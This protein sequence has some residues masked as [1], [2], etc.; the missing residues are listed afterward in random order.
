MAIASPTH[1][2][3]HE[4]YAPATGQGEQAG[5][6]ACEP[7]PFTVQYM[8]SYPTLQPTR[9]SG[10]QPATRRG[11]MFYQEGLPSD[12]L[13]KSEVPG[14]DL[15]AASSGLAGAQSDAGM[16][17]RVAYPGDLVPVADPGSLARQ[18]SMSVAPPRYNVLHGYGEPGGLIRDDGAGGLDVV[19]PNQRAP[20]AKRGP[21][22]DHVER[23]KTALTRKIGSCIRCRMQRIRVSGAAIHGPA[24]AACILMPRPQCNADPD[25]ERGICM[26]CKKI[27][28]KTWRLPCLRLKLSDVVLSKPGQVEGYEW[29]LRW[30][31]DTVL[32]DIG[33]WA[34]SEVKT[35][36][37]TEGYTGHHVQLQVRKFIPQEGDRLERSWVADDG[38][39]KSVK[40]PP[41][42]LVNQ[43]AAKVAYE[44]YIKKGLVECFKRLLGPGEEL[45]WQTYDRAV[46][47]QNDPS[48]PLRERE[49]LTSTMHLWMSIRLTTKS[50]EIVGNETL[51]MQRDITGE[52]SPLRG[53]IPLPPVMGAQIDSI[54]IHQIQSQLRH[55]TLD[56]LQKLTAD[57][58]HKTWLATYLVTFILLHNTALLMKHDAGYA[59]KHGM[60]VCRT[61]SPSPPSLPFSRA[62]VRW[63]LPPTAAGDNKRLTGM[64]P[65]ETICKGRQG[66]T[67]PS[68]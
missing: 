44:S 13:F 19:F 48:L 53:K 38:Q 23:Q 37:V 62:H 68:G 1:D 9:A 11:G 61:H 18:A 3:D 55:E 63:A 39:I 45:L 42:A 27:S 28:S 2:N 8:Q 65:I 33:N 51:G 40:I 36:L 66:Q 14:R 47:L 25:D 6:F 59:R 17:S 31:A 54:L 46:K 30:K 5:L 56:H 64:D 43:D 34:S 26:G 67:V 20:T 15:G 12:S 21:F 60:K 57:N 35:I 32:D 29:T 49:L 24:G 4:A 52:Q 50:F 22:R 10:S 16:A 7:N 58:K 41:Y